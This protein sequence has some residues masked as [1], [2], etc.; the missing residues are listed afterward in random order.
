MLDTTGN[1]KNMFNKK[2][3][4]RKKK[5]IA[6]N[7]IKEYKSPR[8]KEIIRALQDFSI[9]V[10]EGEFV[11][12]VGPSGCGKS[13]FL[14]MVAALE[15]PTEGVIKCDGEP[16]RN[17]GADRGMMFQEYALFPW[18]TVIQNTEFGP[19]VRGIPKEKYKS[20]VEEYIEKLGLKGFEKR[21]PNELS[22]G[23]QQRAALARTFVNDPDIMLM[24]EP[25]SAVDAQ[26][27]EILQEELL[28]LWRS[29]QKTVILVTH[30]V[31][32]AVF[33]SD[34]II[35]M[36]KRPG[37]CKAIFNVD[38]PRPRTIETRNWENYHRLCYKANILIREELVVN[39]H[40]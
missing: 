36:T 21:Y 40:L 18:M 11:S 31:E 7:I 32:E 1:S 29:V 8:D 33:L 37:M 24:D 5:I 35:I 22:G 2:E 30:S 15:H 3:R 25:F 10:Y 16:I 19:N 26:T 39:G 38:L 6:E 13:T 17:P 23:M 12:I 14:R 27:R 9:T 28:S 20:K 34:R 4:P